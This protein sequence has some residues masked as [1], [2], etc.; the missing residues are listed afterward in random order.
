M[1]ID[2]L[3]R[4]GGPAAHGLRIGLF[5]AFAIFSS[6]CLMAAELE[7]ASAQPAKAVLGAAASG[8]NYRVRNPVTT[9]GFLRVYTLETTYG[10]FTVYGDA[11]LQQRRRELAALAALDKESRTKAF[12]NAVVKAGAAPIELAGDLITK[13]GAT[14]KRTLSGIGEVFDRATS[15]LANVGNGGP[16]SAVKS[17]LGVSAAKR[18]I[19]SDLGVDP[20]T[21]FAPLARQLDEF[22]KASVLGGL[23]VKVGISFI[24]GAAGTAVSTASTAHGLGALVRDKTPAQLLEI[25][26]ARLGK[27]GVPRGVADKFLANNL[28]TP[29]DQTVIAGAL[30]QLRGVK[31]LDIYVDRLAQADRRDIAVFLR[32]RTAMM[33]AYQERTGAIARVVSVR[34][35]PLTA[36]HDGS[37]MFLGPLDLV[38]WNALVS[39]TFDVVTPAIRKTGAKGELIF[40]I[41]GKATPLSQRKL[42]QLGWSVTSPL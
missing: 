19:A 20:Y 2:D 21:D 37:V 28:Y 25:N 12:G 33:A 34:G 18:K 6:D 8:V 9:D 27:L 38:S 7:N 29:A 36:Q 15:G 24:P 1:R 11:M 41:S 10:T 35:I 5:V 16:D 13:P 14:V 42:K 30:Q 32:T 40:S 31:D 3:N 17:A 39:K 23:V 26:R 22:A 4:F